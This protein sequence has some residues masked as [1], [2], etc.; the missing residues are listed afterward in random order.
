MRGWFLACLL[1][2]GAARAEDCPGC[3]P[4]KE[5]AAHEEADAKAIKE[6]QP[7]L[8]DRDLFKRREGIEKLAWAAERHSN[9][10]SKKLTAEM[11]RL[12]SDPEAGVKTVAL[13]K[14]GE[15]GEE[16]VSIPAIAREIAAREKD[17]GNDKPTKEDEIK[18]WEDTMRILEACFAALGKTPLNPSA[19]V[20][21]EKG[22]RHSNSWVVAAAAKSAGSFRKSKLVVKALV[23]Q[24]AKFFASNVTEG[25]SAAW[26]AISVALPLATEC[27]DIPNQKD[28]FDAGRWNSDWQKW[29]RANDKTLK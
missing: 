13:E 16:S 10:R 2:A 25:N 8:R 29:M 3:N 11:A 15:F 7:L 12:L 17:A 27:N 26:T 14:L 23:D 18:K 21:L 20:S 19:A 5:C 24:L 9:V 22:L 6:A 4:K 1:A 28:Q